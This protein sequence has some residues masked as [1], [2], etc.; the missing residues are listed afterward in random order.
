MCSEAL[1]SPRLYEYVC[2][3]HDDI[4][5]RSENWGKYIITVLAEKTIGVL[6][7]AGSTYASSIPSPWWI[8][9]FA[10]MSS[11]MRCNFIHHTGKGIENN[12]L[13]VNSNLQLFEVVVLD[14]VWFC[15]RKKVW[16]K[17][18]FDESYGG[19]HFYDLDFSMAVFEKG[20]HNQ[21]THQVLIEHFSSGQMDGKWIGAALLFNKKW[22]K[23]LP[24]GIG[25]MKDEETR[26]VKKEALKNILTVC[27]NYKQD[28]FSW[29]TYWFKYFLLAPF[30][31]ETYSVLW[32]KMKQ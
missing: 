23:V 12:L 9:N 5:F 21:V 2:F 3:L 27:L 7:I 16:E 14:G 17:V 19:F 10:D 18:R 8:S 1:W 4:L 6:G 28:S 29:Y 15:C 13:P 31:K 26:F 30:R 22:K 25:N 24:V 11:F 32:G 20:Y